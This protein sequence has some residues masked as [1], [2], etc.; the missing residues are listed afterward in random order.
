MNEAID[1]L[2]SLIREFEGCKL[3]AYRCPAKKWTIGYGQTFG[4]HEGM[5]WTKE[6]AEADLQATAKE[7]LESA[8]KVS[9]TL[10]NA[11]PERQASIADFI[12]NCGLANY[13]KSTLKK[14]IDW[15][16]WEHARMEIIKWNKAGGH[17]LKGLVRRR[18]AEADLLKS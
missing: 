16:Q 10:Q 9:P 1:I 8:L 2:V 6:Q 17:V 13:K 15:R 4:V 3:Q 7:V 18:A 12:Y 11:S 14:Y 5:V